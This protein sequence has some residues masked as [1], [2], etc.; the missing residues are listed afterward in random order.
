MKFYVDLLG[1][2]K[3]NEEWA[4]IP[5]FRLTYKKDVQKLTVRF[6]RSEKD[7]G[8]VYSGK[9]TRKTSV[10]DVMAAVNTKP[11]GAPQKK[12]GLR[13]L[14]RIVTWFFSQMDAGNS[15]HPSVGAI[16]CESELMSPAAA[17]KL[18]RA[19]DKASKDATDA[20]KAQRSQGAY[21]VE[22]DY[23]LTLKADKVTKRFKR[24]VVDTNPVGVTGMFYFPKETPDTLT[25]KITGIGEGA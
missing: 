15:L 17:F 21:E 23:T 11:L 4:G 9:A 12:E 13:M 18:A 1:L 16:F 10:D 5:F 20:V 14:R 24:F 25:V 3:E 2:V 19:A 8:V 7:N 6:F 22:V